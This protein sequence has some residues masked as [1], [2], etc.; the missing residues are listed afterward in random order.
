MRALWSTRGKRH[1]FATGPDGEPRA[2]AETLYYL[3]LGAS[4]MAKIE[5]TDAPFEAAMR[6]TRRILRQEQA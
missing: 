5:R 4:L 6:T 2:T 1:G 3:W